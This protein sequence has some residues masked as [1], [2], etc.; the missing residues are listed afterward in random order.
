MMP[1]TGRSGALDW[2]GHLLLLHSAESERV[3]ALVT[4]IRRGLDNNAYQQ[5][6]ERQLAAGTRRLRLVGEVDFGADRDSWAEWARFEALINTGAPDL[7]SRQRG[8]GGRLLHR[9]PRRPPLTGAT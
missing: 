9:P 8:N 7:R 4:W 2:K 3:S 1:D 6:A 5:I